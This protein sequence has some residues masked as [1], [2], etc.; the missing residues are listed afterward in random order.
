M[1]YKV[2]RMRKLFKVTKVYIIKINFWEYLLGEIKFLYMYFLN[3]N[4]L[5]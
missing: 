1:F 2:K 3:E 4:K 5:G